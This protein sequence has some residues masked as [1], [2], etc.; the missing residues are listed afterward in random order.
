MGQVN[1]TRATVPSTAEATVSTSA[2]N[3]FVAATMMQTKVARAWTTLLEQATVW[4]PRDAFGAWGTSPAG[5]RPED[6][7]GAVRVAAMD[8]AWRRNVEAFL[9]RKTEGI[10]Y[11]LSTMELEM[12]LTGMG[13]AAL[14]YA[15]GQDQVSMNRAVDRSLRRA[16]FESL[17]LVRA[18]RS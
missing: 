15:A 16:W 2:V 9:W 13:D 17:P 8:A 1:G 18:L 6:V 7:P 5:T 14:D 10:A 11:A 3:R 12:G 4:L